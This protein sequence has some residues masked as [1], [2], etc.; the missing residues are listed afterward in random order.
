MFQTASQLLDWAIGLALVPPS[1]TLEEREAVI[2]GV[3]VLLQ[4]TISI[5]ENALTTLK[6][7]PL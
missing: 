3:R 4:V 1:A 2:S 6:L 7:H 5:A